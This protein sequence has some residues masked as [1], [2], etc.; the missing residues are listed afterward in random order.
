M[1]VFV[2]LQHHKRG[3]DKLVQE[4]DLDFVRNDLELT[5]LLLRPLNVVETHGPEIV[6]VPLKTLYFLVDLGNLFVGEVRFANEFAEGIFVLP[7]VE[8]LHLPRRR[9]HYT[10]NGI[11]SARVE[12]SWLE[13]IGRLLRLSIIRS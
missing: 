12:S 8:E 7:Q 4:P 2:S 6:T 3:V 10:A 13:R 1:L 11:T 9:T 5:D